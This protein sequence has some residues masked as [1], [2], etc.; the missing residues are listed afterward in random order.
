MIKNKTRG[1]EQKKKEDYFKKLKGKKL[2]ILSKKFQAS[3]VHSLRSD[4]I[5]YAAPVRERALKPNQVNGKL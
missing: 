4:F 1:K 3:K 5:I 2:C